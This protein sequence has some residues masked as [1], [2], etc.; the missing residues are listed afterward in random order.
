MQNKLLDL[1][2]FKLHLVVRHLPDQELIHGPACYMCEYWVE[3]MVQD[4]KRT[5]TNRATHDPEIVYYKDY[6]IRERLIDWRAEFPDECKSTA[7]QPPGPWQHG[8]NAEIRDSGD[9]QS[10]TLMGTG[11]EDPPLEIDVAQEWPA[12]KKVLLADPQYYR[13][14][15][16]P[17]PNA[18][19]W[20]SADNY[21][22][23][24][25]F[26]DMLLYQR[27]PQLRLPTRCVVGSVRERNQ[28]TCC[29]W[30]HMRYDGMANPHYMLQVQYHV[31]LTFAP[32]EHYIFGEVIANGAEVPGVAPGKPAPLRFAITKAFP[33]KPVPA[34]D[35]PCANFV[36]DLDAEFLRVDNA[37]TGANVLPVATDAREITSACPHRLGMNVESDEH[38]VGRGHGGL[39]MRTSKGVVCLT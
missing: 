29:S 17:V 27:F 32:G 3:R 8:Y 25:E 18:A 19:D 23:S 2:T 26:Q 21:M 35:C 22:N 28:T 31:M 5:T 4:V 38:G 16:W 33:A 13:G 11:K 20:H 37:A 12:I 14:L 1:C 34:R 7:E 9:A 15:G 30:V 39:F 6:L 10:Y 36:P 24:Q